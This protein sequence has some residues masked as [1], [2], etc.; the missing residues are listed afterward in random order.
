MII[1]GKISKLNIDNTNLCIAFL[2]Y[3]HGYE[4]CPEEII[5]HKWFSKPAEDWEIQMYEDALRMSKITD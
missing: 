5:V 1:V 2:G 4:W 3:A